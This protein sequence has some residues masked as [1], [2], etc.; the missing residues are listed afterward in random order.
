MPQS[1]QRHAEHGEIDV[2]VVALVVLV[3]AMSA[4]VVALAL[5]VSSTWWWLLIAP[6]AFAGWTMFEWRRTR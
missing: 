5:L 2:A 1:T 6:L 4:V 3:F